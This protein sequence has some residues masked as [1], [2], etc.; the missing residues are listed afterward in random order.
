LRSTSTTPAVCAAVRTLADNPSVTVGAFAR[1]APP[2]WLA[3]YSVNGLRCSDA[4]GSHWTV[5]NRLRCGTA[6][7]DATAT[8]ISK[9]DRLGTR[10]VAPVARFRT[11][12]PPNT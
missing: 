12:G 6:V 8:I 3:A 10:L 11:S 1:T 2:S 7:L 9:L 5:P 4:F